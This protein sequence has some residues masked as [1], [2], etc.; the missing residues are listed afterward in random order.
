MTVNLRSDATAKAEKALPAAPSVLPAHS[1][2][3]LRLRCLSL[4]C[5]LRCAEERERA[6]KLSA[7][8]KT[9]PKMAASPPR[10]EINQDDDEVAE[11]NKQTKYRTG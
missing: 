8:A 2:E 10:N 6:E 7:Q 3:G 9:D 4:S 5:P 11:D 1:F